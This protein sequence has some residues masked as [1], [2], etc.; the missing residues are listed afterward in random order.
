MI[1][2]I[3]FTVP[4]TRLPLDQKNDIS[5]NIFYPSS[6]FLDP[7][8]TVRNHIITTIMRQVNKRRPP[9]KSFHHAAICHYLWSVCVQ[10]KLSFQ[11]WRIARGADYCVCHN[12]DRAFKPQPRFLPDQAHPMNALFNSWHDLLF[13][14]PTCNQN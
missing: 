5:S 3:V 10:L 8:L 14:G 6:C 11:H 2:S 7:A 9:A 13:I 1:G 4:M 12:L